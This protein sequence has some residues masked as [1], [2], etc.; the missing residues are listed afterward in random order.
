LRNFIQVY[1]L[2][3]RWKTLSFLGLE[4]EVA[5]TQLPSI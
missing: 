4:W 5:L 2:F 3:R 1:V